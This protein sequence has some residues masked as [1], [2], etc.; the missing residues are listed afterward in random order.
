MVRSL[1]QDLATL[2]ADRINAL[3][4]AMHDEAFEV[5]SQGAPG[6]DF[7]ETRYAY[8]RYIGQGHEIPVPLPLSACGP[9]DGAVF[10]RAFEA[11]YRELYGRT[12]DGVGIEALSWTLGLSAPAPVA[13]T[14]AP[15]GLAAGGD[16]PTSRPESAQSLWDV[17]RARRVEA[18]VY[19]RESLA[20]GNPF[21]GPAL[22]AEDQTTTVVPPGWRA[23][24]DVRGNI[25]L[26]RLGDGVATQRGESA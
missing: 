24:M 10:R 9:T 22:I 2:E 5:V 8:M 26:E 12:I 1:R 19:R 7:T 13:P 20:P 3:F 11:A 16:A 23:S 21:D 6:A 4:A 25:L 15:P 18:A 17:A 14:N